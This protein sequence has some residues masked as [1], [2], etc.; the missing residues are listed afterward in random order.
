MAEESALRASNKEALARKQTQLHYLDVINHRLSFSAASSP[1]SMTDGQRSYSRSPNT[2]LPRLSWA[3]LKVLRDAKFFN[4]TG[5][6]LSNS[7]AIASYGSLV[8]GKGSPP[9]APRVSVDPC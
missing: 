5:G 1:L 7:F 4:F 9:G 2:Q 8:T 3:G 6:G